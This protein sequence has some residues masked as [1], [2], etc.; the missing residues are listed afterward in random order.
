MVEEEPGRGGSGEVGG[1][2]GGWGQCH[3]ADAGDVRFGGGSGGGAGTYCA[4]MEQKQ[5][6]SQL[7]R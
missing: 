6:W 5:R 1:G 7:W 3:E 2:G 4:Q